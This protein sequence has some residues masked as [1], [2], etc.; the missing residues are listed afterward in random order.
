MK[1]LLPEREQSNIVKIDILTPSSIA[2]LQETDPLTPTSQKHQGS[3]SLG[4][5]VLPE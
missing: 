3:H 5:L 1:S 2:E 4:T